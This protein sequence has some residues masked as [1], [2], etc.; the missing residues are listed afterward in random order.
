MISN[1]E[2]AIRMRLAAQLMELH[3][4]NPFKA[5]AYDTAAFRIERL[6]QQLKDMPEEEIHKVPGIGD[7]IAEKV[8][9]MLVEGTF[10]EL[11]KLEEETPEGLLGL[12]SVRGLGAKKLRQLWQELNVTNAQE[13][14]EACEQNKLTPL[15]GFSEKTQ[16]K[17]H[18]I[19]TFA[20]EGQGKVLYKLAHEQGE[21][22]RQELE[23]LPLQGQLSPTG[24]Y[25]RR[26]ETV[27][28]LEFMADE[29]DSDIIRQHM[30]RQ[31]MA[32]DNG[33]GKRTWYTKSRN[34]PVRIYFSK[35]E[36]FARNLLVTTGSAA[37]LDL[38]TEIPKAETEADIYKK[39][40]LHYIIP[41]M[42]EGR[43][44]VEKA[45]QGEIPV[46]VKNS[47]LKG[48][49]HNH[50]RYSDGRNSLEQMAQACMDLGLEYFGISDHSK[51][52][53]YANGLKETELPA[54]FA[55]IEKL[56]AQYQKEGKKFRIFKSIES[57]ILNDGSLDYDEGWL[58]QF[59]FI[60]A[61]IHSNLQMK[62]EAANQRLIRAI[63]NPYTTVLGHMTGR[64]LLM[65]EG[66]PVNHEKIIDACAANGVAIEINANPRRLDI[67]WRWIDKAL[68]KGI[69]LSIN[70]D[71]HTVEEIGYMQYGI[72]A[73]M[74][75]GLTKEHVLN[76]KSLEEVEAWFAGKLNS[77]SG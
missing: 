69:M 62:E 68:E 15:K 35:K 4:A 38:L 27:S 13:L 7:K 25:R 8:R 77:A 48:C 71:A 47:D 14:L 28:V 72:Y 6:D 19:V 12:M 52:A 17:V 54:Y 76:T 32:K 51:S 63:E 75:A 41:E 1:K 36:N 60:V 73:A 21:L 39:L 70:P 66:Y 33:E 43:N 22:I 11:R 30:D 67:D 65:R 56:N 34:I 18:E 50:S 59:D 53:F 64:L 57:D 24:D 10:S 20:L 46:P 26:T 42:R 29:T 55:E 49:L 58:K 37:H 40:A 16:K 74:K 44:E 9:Q 2:I 45:R 61:S 3:G 31:H 5:K 23:A